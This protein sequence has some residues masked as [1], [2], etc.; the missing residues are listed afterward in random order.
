L[1]S[2]SNQRPVVILN[3]YSHNGNI[4][5]DN[6]GHLIHIDFGF[7]FSNSPGSVGFEVAPFKLPEEYLELLGGTESA[8]YSKFIDLIA[9]CFISVR[10]KADWIIGLVELMEHGSRLPCFTGI[11]NP[12][13]SNPPPSKVKSSS[14]ALRDRLQLGLTD[15]QVHEFIRNL[16][17][18]SA[19]SNFT[20][21]YDTFQVLF[22]AYYSIMRM[23]YCIDNNSS[24]A[25]VIIETRAKRELL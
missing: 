18:S 21:L 2:P 20:K 25:R 5:I 17:Q 9:K 6:E 13:S 12:N 10:K 15:T 8:I 19:N 14:S 23:E 22:L 3:N 4:L 7:M 1:L 16:A 24:E 11:T